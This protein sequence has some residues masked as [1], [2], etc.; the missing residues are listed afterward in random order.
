MCV[1]NRSPI[2]KN[3]TSGLCSTCV[4]LVMLRCIFR[5]LYAVYATD[6]LYLP[7]FVV[8]G[9]VCKAIKNLRF[10]LM[11]TSIARLGSYIFKIFPSLRPNYV[12]FLWWTRWYLSLFLF[13]RSWWHQG[14]R[15]SSPRSQYLC[16]N[17]NNVS[18]GV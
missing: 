5:K 3:S 11:V 2:S 17:W 1:W 13:E 16:G 9:P 12:L 15:Y 10:W 7:F 18:W 8:R 4:G 6:F 14:S